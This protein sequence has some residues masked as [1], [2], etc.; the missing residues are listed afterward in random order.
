MK[1]TKKVSSSSSSD[2]RHV[3]DDNDHC[4][5]VAS[6]AAEEVAGTTEAAA[7]AAGDVPDV[8][9]DENN[10]AD[11][12][13]QVSPK[14]RH[15]GRAMFLASKGGVAPPVVNDNNQGGPIAAAEAEDIVATLGVIIP[16][17]RRIADVESAVEDFARG[18]EAIA[19]PEPTTDRNPNTLVFD[20]YLAPER[21]R[22][23]EAIDAVVL[24][25]TEDIRLSDRRKW[26]WL[27]GTAL[28]VVGVMVLSL[29]L[30]RNKNARNP[31]AVVV[32]K[33]V[34][35]SAP[36]AILSSTGRLAGILREIMTH[37][38]SPTLEQDLTNPTS[39]QY[40][41]ALWM[42]EEDVHPATANLT[43]PL[44]QTSLDLLQFRQR[45][46]LVTF[47][48][49]TDGDGWTDRCNFLTP[50]LHVCDWNC[51]A[52]SE[53]FQSYAVPYFY[54]GGK[55]MGANCGKSIQNLY[56]EQSVL[57]D[58]VLTLHLSK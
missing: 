3:Q 11:V 42:A 50:S 45:Y 13:H 30:T 46:A 33:D 49:A 53:P 51:I 58:L 8:D 56:D 52:D 22:R 23:A 14:K 2:T 12:H 9:Q 1:D 21:S 24:D 20:A 31:S 15:A 48:Y 47:Y 39:P 7:A 55:Q 35:S 28:F 32:I 38:E 5:L 54:A 41:A 16:D 29:L 43:Y 57:D 40:R 27:F 19:P 4:R 36:T 37:F 34:P 25:D 44:N 6:T 26:A 10:M 18:G 17:E